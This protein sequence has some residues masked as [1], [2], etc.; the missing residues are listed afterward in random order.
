MP[1]DDANAL[2]VECDVLHLLPS[3][4][5]EF[6]VNIKPIAVASK[7]AKSSLNFCGVETSAASDFVLD[8][9]RRGYRL[10]SIPQS[11]F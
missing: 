1:N 4:S 9:I 2:Q 6:S 5:D 11:A 8:M 7:V 3:S 10:P